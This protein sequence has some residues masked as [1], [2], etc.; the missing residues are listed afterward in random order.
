MS[1]VQDLKVRISAD[2]GQFNS[3]MKKLSS[4]LQDSTKQFSGLSQAGEAVS[5]LG[6]KLMPL[7][8]AVG[9]VATASAKTAIDFDSAMNKVSA[10]SGATGKDLDS[11]RELAKRMG[12]ET[13][14]SAT[15]SAEALSYMGMAG[16]D[17]SQMIDALPGVLA[18]ASAG[19]TDL[20]L[21]SDIVTDGLTAMGLEA[22]DTQK[23]VDI[24]ASTCRS[25]NTSIEL[26]GETMKYVG[27]TAGA[28][29]IDM[30]DLSV[31]IGLMANAGIKGSQAGTALRAGLV[32]LVKPT[33]QMAKAMDEYGI[34]IQKNSD[35]SV[36]F[37]GTMEH[38]RE[39]LGKLDETT[40]ANVISTIF[41]K[42]AMA[43][44]SA[45]INATDKDFQNLSKAIA[46]SDGVAQSMA[47]TM[48]EGAGGAL[49]EMKS[50]LE[51]VAITIG[52][53]LTP[54]IEKFADW[55]SQLCRKFQELSPETQNA[56]I[57]FGG[58][59]AI[60][61][62][63]LVVVGSLMKG[64]ATLKIAS[65]ALGVGMGTLSAGFLLIPLAI[66]AVIAGIALLI[67]NWDTVKEKA[68]ELA[69][70]VG[71]CWDNIV[72]W[73]SEKWNQVCDF[74]SN[75]WER[76]CST[77]EE[78]LIIAGAK[79]K[80]GW[81]K[82]VE[83]TTNIWNGICDVVSTVW[84][85]ICNLVQVG[86][87]LIAEVIKAGVQI[88]L[89][90][91]TF[92]WENCKDFIIPIWEKIC[93]YVSEKLELVKT[94]V[95]EKLEAVKNFFV[96]KWTLVRDKTVEI[97]EKIASVVS[98]KLEKVKS[99]V[100]EKL[101]AIKNFFVEKWTTARDKTVE[102]YNKISTTI[103][104][105]LEQ[106]KSYVSSKLE[107]IKS[108]FSD[109]FEQAKAKVVEKMNSIKQNIQD[110][111][112]SAK[113]VAS[114]ALDAIKSK[115]NIFGPIAS[116]VSEKFN[117]IKSTISDKINSAK[118]AVSKA[119]EK[120]KSILNITLPFPKIKLPH[121]SF[122]GKFSLN[123]P[124]VPKF[125]VVWRNKGAIYKRRTILPDGTGVGDAKFGGVG[126]NPEA[127]L[128]INKLPELLGLDKKENNGG[129]S[130]NIE[131]FENNREQDIEQLA[132]ELAFYLKRKKLIGGA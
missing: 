93:S 90:P 27:S 48:M 122:T 87:M 26:M 70:K 81:D 56:I 31:G 82:C 35:G 99:W 102:I 73:T 20:A 32:N 107:A 84:D 91:W 53:R 132:N 18:L 128:P 129:I 51:G 37:M 100:S 40:Q 80:E 33:D 29:G 120:M 115:F 55:I 43:G 14:F 63:I 88:I 75:A 127:I 60:I 10:V 96:E 125:N 15:E 13:K 44:W 101:E 112:N 61:P 68:K 23:F 6:K 110:K 16:W 49:T 65:V 104:E 131:R 19:G 94:Y 39:K 105:K 106:A 98:E 121:F 103:S 52:E 79:V 22:K 83:V 17:A 25:S 78:W 45:I 12:S 97:Y 108:Y 8:V 117:K 116:S 71:E 123:P 119:I 34:A 89:L 47:D 30:G 118:D 126:N 59:L 24:M 62:P 77:V 57:L 1:K 50:A 5:G 46:E 114:S 54:Y 130:L 21:T 58:I 67:A 111:L 109:K 113:S 74:M 76:I 64:F 41:G 2:I 92:I 36:D 7:T 3:E 9:G 38:L 124:S 42:E 95:S 86:I 11:L 85:T 28:L 72:Q 4:S 69:S 66:T